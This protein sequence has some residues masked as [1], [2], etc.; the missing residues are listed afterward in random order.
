MR[1]REEDLWKDVGEGGIQ[2]S[3]MSSVRE[4][5][6]KRLREGESEGGRE[7]VGRQAGREGERKGRKEG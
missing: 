2:G 1:V 7:A 5:G 4:G 3:S 6:R